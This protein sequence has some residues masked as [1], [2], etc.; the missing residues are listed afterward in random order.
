[1]IN[2]LTP[3][4]RATH[5]RRQLRSVSDVN[6][7]SSRPARQKLTRN[8]SSRLMNRPFLRQ[9]GRG[10]WARAQRLVTSGMTASSSLGAG[11]TRSDDCSFVADELDQLAVR[12][13]PP[14]DA[15]GEGFE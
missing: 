10:V 15:R 3:A 4:R 14:V 13:Q 9:G 1:M 7:V 12:I 5:T 6:V 2:A 11:A 8:P